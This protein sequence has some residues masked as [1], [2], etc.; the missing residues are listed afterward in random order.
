M[1]F[2]AMGMNNFI[3]ILTIFFLPFIS[4]GIDD[5][6]IIIYVKLNKRLLFEQ[7]NGHI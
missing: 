1:T 5:I 4:N 2:K 3:Y 6:I 7:K